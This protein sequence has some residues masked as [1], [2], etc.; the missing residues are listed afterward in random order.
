MV[1]TH[2]GGDDDTDA[3]F[4]TT[5]TFAEQDGKTRLTMRALFASAAV[6]DK[7]VE[8]YGAIAG[9]NQTLDRL[10]EYLAKTGREAYL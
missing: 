3:P 6:R 7:T 4:Q 5:V 2:S 10:G 9:G 8:E 1:Y